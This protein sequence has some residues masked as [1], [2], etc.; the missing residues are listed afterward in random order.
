MT[1]FRNFPSI[2]MG[3]FRGVLPPNL[4]KYGLI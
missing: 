2:V 4:R 1:I 3:F